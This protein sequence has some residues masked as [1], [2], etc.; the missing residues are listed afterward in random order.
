VSSRVAVLG[1]VLASP[2][3][4]RVE[5]AFLAFGV[6][7][8]GVWVAALV[9]AYER[10][11]TTLTAVFAVAQLLPA[12]VVAPLAAREVD[13]RGAAATLRAG[14]GLQAVAIAAGGAA[15]LL[16]APS[17][18]V[19]G[20]AIVAASAVTLTRP[21]QAA[22]LPGLVDGPR[23]L[24]AANVVTGWAQSVSLLAGPLLA[25]VFIGLD[26]PGAAF[27]LF[28]G[29]V[30]ASAVLVTP[31]VRG[32]ASVTVDE[33]ATEAGSATVPH[34]LRAEPGIAAVVAV[35]TT[36][37]VAI[38]ALDVL[39]VVLALTLLGL[40]GSGAGY[41][42]AAFGAG[43]VL[44]SFAALLLVGRD[45]LVAPLLAAVLGW[46]AAFLALA[47]WPTVAG[48]FALLA[49]AGITRSLLDVAAR[50]ILH[51]TVPA[52]AHGRVFGVLEG[53]AM[54]GLAIGSISVPAIVGIGG[55]RLAVGVAGGLLVIVAIG[56]ATTLRALERAAHVPAV[57]LAL[58]RGSPLFSL[59]AAPVLED[60][61]RVLVAQPVKPGEVIIR[62][63]EIGE[64]YYLLAS[65]ALHASVAGTQVTTLAPG[66]G[67]GEIALLRDGIRAA[68]VVAEEP[69]VIFALD[70]GPF[71][72]AV[73]GSRRAALAAEALV[74][75]Q[76]G[77]TPR[78]IDGA[79]TKH[80]AGLSV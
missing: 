45:R 15:M 31:L 52:R 68:T 64:R 22:L 42:D 69:S 47:V 80:D 67:F 16:H 56:S 77:P 3:L 27:A 2:R 72:E 58:L 59:L 32:T 18:V 37:F 8:Y 26:G 50:T 66:D 41:L 12:A 43:A 28:A 35:V 46:G 61:A 21:A 75:A 71:L 20:G 5:L 10:G 53:V 14:Y 17:V 9:Y 7:E 54:L 48:A 73:T 40:G 76:V 60:L 55:P 44:G 65:G 13:R 29:A 38:G 62:E 74:T 33:P 51:R 39:V 63:G 36:E 6:A 1:D 30:T 24:T 19:Y 70:R 79:A 23:E 49:A 4:R 34:I 25:G 57:Q 11:G 78:P